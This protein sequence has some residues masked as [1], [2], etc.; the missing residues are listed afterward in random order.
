MARKWLFS[1]VDMENEESNQLKWP[2]F[3]EIFKK[4]YAIQKNYKI[5]I[6]DLS[7]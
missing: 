6:E 4:E 2:V 5:I 7:N 1:I 3:K